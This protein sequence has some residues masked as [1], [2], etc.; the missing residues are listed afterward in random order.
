MYLCSISLLL[1]T[2]IIVYKEWFLVL[3]KSIEI[4]RNGLVK[5]SKTIALLRNRTSQKTFR[6]ENSRFF[7]VFPPNFPEIFWIVPNF[8]EFFWIFPKCE[9]LANVLHTY[10]ASASIYL[11]CEKNIRND[12][13]KAVWEIKERLYKSLATGTLY[14]FTVFLINNNKCIYIFLEWNPNIWPFVCWIASA[15]EGGPLA[16]KF[17]IYNSAMRNTQGVKIRVNNGMLPQTSPTSLFSTTQG[18]KVTCDIT[19]FFK[20]YLSTL[21]CQI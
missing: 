17:L 19:Y 11:I 14:N 18:E 2:L 9:S 13:T 16:R 20:Y 7:P 1:S 15:R 21:R 5:S 3:V 4:V 6:K 10:I 12:C 8:F